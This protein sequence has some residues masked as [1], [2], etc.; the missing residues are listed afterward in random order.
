MTSRAKNT[1]SEALLPASDID[2][3]D[4]PK[5]LLERFYEKFSNTPAPEVAAQLRAL[6]Q[7]QFSEPEL[8]QITEVRVRASAG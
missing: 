7:F 2:R 6:D 5:T 1:F 4:E 3:S 8:H